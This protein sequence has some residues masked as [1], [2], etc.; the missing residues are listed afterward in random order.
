[1]N[2]MIASIMLVLLCVPFAPIAAT[3]LGGGGGQA[4]YGT[5][6]IV[7]SNQ[8]VRYHATPGQ[9][10]DCWVG[11]VKMR[12]APPAPPSASATITVPAHVAASAVFAELYWVIL[13]DTV[14]PATETFNGA[15]LVRVA[16]GPVTTDPCWPTANAYA[17]R[18]N[19]LP[20]LAAGVNTLAG[21]PDNGVLGGAPNVEGASLV[22]VFATATVDK[23]IVVMSGNDLLDQNT[24]PGIVSL[25]L[26]IVTPPGTGADLT[27]ITGDGQ[28]I[29]DD[30]ALWNGI[31]LASPDAFQGLD[32]GPGTTGGGGGYWDTLEFAVFTGPPNEATIDTTPYPATFDCLNWVA[33]VMCTK[34]RNCQVTPAEPST[35]GRL[36][37]LYRTPD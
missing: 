18:A 29:W 9:C 5:D 32:P 21:F 12:N 36:K 1:M 7:P 3:E 17:W 34:Y 37:N 19:V 15:P 33:T 24:N 14:P 10:L 23:E 13:D 11:G 2:R 25:S 6:T 8:E 22:V 35:W 27:F 16:S 20:L 28:N 30:D 4:P 26:P 31:V